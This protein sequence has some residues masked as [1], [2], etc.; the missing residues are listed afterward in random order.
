MSKWTAL[1]SVLLLP[2]C[3]SA[4]DGTTFKNVVLDGIILFALDK[5]MEGLDGNGPVG[6]APEPDFSRQVEQ[7]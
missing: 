3:M 5:G 6:S 4:A 7:R 2:S 1:A